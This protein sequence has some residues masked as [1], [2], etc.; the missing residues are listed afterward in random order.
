MNTYQRCFHLL[1]LLVLSM[2]IGCVSSGRKVDESKLARIKVG[3]TTETEV[4]ALL[5]EPNDVSRSQAAGGETKT[6]SYHFMQSKAKAINYVPYAN[7]VSSGYDHRNQTVFIAIDTSGKV[8]SI[9][10]SAGQSETRTG[11]LGHR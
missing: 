5:G 7:L 4:I 8:A 1:T 9:S 11:M 3:E 10:S 6:L 2:V